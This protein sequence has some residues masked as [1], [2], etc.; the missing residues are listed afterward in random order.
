MLLLMMI[1][2]SQTVKRKIFRRLFTSRC[3]STGEYFHIDVKFP[4]YGFHS[5]IIIIPVS[6]RL[7]PAYPLGISIQRFPNKRARLR[8]GT[9]RQ[10][11]NVMGMEGEGSEKE[12]IEGRYVIF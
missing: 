8:R 9:R 5:T 10:R 12:E 6:G 4:S 1:I 2:M 3:T 7:S 11:G